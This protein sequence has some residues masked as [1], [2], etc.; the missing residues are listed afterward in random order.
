MWR[1]GRDEYAPY[2]FEIL[3]QAGFAYRAWTPEAWLNERPAGITIV[4]GLDESADWSSV[5][6]AYCDNGNAVLAVGDT[7]G[8]DGALGVRR[9]RAAK[10]GWIGWN[11]S[12]LADGLRSSFHFFGAALVTT[13]EGVDAH[14]EIETLAGAK[15]GHPAVTVKRCSAG[16]AALF[17]VDLARTF[18][19]IQQGMPVLKDGV[20]SPDGTGAIDDDIYKSDDGVVLDWVR[21]RDSVE[22][23]APF[24][25][26]PIV[27]EFRIVF[28]RLLHRLRETASRPLA[29]VWFWPEGREAIGHISHDTDGNLVDAAGMMLDRLKEADV[30]SSWCVI[31]PGYPE[32][33]YRRIV[34]DGHEVALHYNALE[35]EGAYW[36]EGLFNEQL[37]RLKSRMAAIGEPT[38]IWTNKNH[39]LRWEGGV[40]FYAWC[41][42]AGIVVE[43]SKGGTKQGNKGFSAGTCHPYLPVADAAE[44]NRTMGV[45]SNP[46]L[47]WDPPVPLRCTAAE[48][49]ALV[50][51]SKDVYGVAHFL[52]HP[53]SFKTYGAEVGD[54]F[55]ELIRYG[56]EQGLPWWTAVELYR[57]L[58]L[59]RTVEATV[60]EDALLIR[61]GGDCAGLTILLPADS[62]PAEGTAASVVRSVR[63]VERFGLRLQEWV[64]DAP[65]GELRIPLRVTVGAAG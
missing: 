48:A 61:A 58:E 62:V 35:A 37:D 29:Q 16:A 65:R 28:V 44:R 12:P 8:L 23:G 38:R 22:G 13:A 34:A 45:Y 18:C 7:H 19:L 42:K 33:V 56:K 32:D 21:D 63:A 2:L 43:Q 30:R 17:A 20:P 54:A 25:L 40:Q 64:L 57:W 6:Q 11:G 41:E 3:R 15:N 24:Y 36:D 55:V 5:F 26:H 14:G 60:E 39:Y 46:T 52:Y 1:Q 10:E 31:M 4:I 51:R 50:D 53:S 47:A 49:R 59:R 9:V 27:D